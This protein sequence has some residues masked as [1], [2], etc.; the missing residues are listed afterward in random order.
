MRGKRKREGDGWVH[1]GE[2]MMDEKKK[3]MIHAQRRERR[4]RRRREN[5]GKGKERIKETHM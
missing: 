3:W 1:R 4:K 5:K 2:M